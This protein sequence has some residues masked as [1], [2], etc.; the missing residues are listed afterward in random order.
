MSP[1][2]EKQCPDEKKESETDPT[3]SKNSV[4]NPASRPQD[5]A[6][7]A[8]NDQQCHNNVS[9]AV[10]LSGWRPRPI[11][12][13]GSLVP[14]DKFTF[15]VAFFTG[16]L[17]IATSIQ[18][19]AFIQSERAFISLDSVTINKLEAGKPLVIQIVVKNS[20]KST[21]T[22]A[23]VFYNSDIQLPLHRKY[24]PNKA[25]LPPVISGGTI[26]F[27]F[28]NPDPLTEDN[29][30]ALATGAIDFYVWGYIA[31]EDEF[32]IFGH[33]IVGFCVVH[34]RDSGIGFE[35]CH[36]KEYTYTH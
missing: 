22:T 18:V 33:R 36:T 34:D 13:W 27:R 17:F 9:C 12:W 32:S 7:R 15:V 19:W 35:T 20:G 14:I 3:H 10:K 28:F 26:T 11:R 2:Q 4:D 21:A 25:E 24:G 29:I 23:V 6:E 31:F 30:R 8:Q 1:D 16:L 5:Q